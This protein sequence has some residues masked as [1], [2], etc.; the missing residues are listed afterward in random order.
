MNIVTCA[1]MREANRL[2]TE[3]IGIPQIVLMENTALKIL[4]EII[5]ECKD[6]YNKNIIVFAGYGNNGGNALAVA[7]H[8]FT[9][10]AN[11]KVKLVPNDSGEMSPNMVVNLTS[12][13]NMTIDIETLDSSKIQKLPVAIMGSEIVIDGIFGIGLNK[14]IIGIAI[15]VIDAINALNKKVFSLDLP[16]G[17]NC[18]TGR[19]QGRSVKAYKTLTF[20]LPKVGLYMYD[21]PKYTGEIVV[22]DIGIPKKVYEQLNIKLNIITHQDAI[23]PKRYNESSKTSYGKVLVIGGSKGMAGSVTLTSSAALKSGAGLVYLGAPESLNSVL[24][25]KLT[26]VIL[27]SLED[28]SNGVLSI[29]A[30]ETVKENI[31]K[32]NVVAIGPGIS[33][34]TG[35][36]VVV[37]WISE[38]SKVPV[39]L[40]ADALGALSK[41]LSVLS[42]AKAQIIITPHTS[43]MAK[44]IG[45]TIEDVQANRLEVARKFAKKWNVITVLKGAYTIVATPSG[46]DYINVNGNNGMSTAG[47]GDVLTGVI[48]G[49]IA[50]DL[51]PVN[52][53]V[54]GI[55]LHGLA[56]DLCAVNKGYHGMTASDIL[57]QIP[58]TIKKV[59]LSL[60]ED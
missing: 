22:L 6:V 49:L 41:D 30:L 51:A 36:D 5:K 24:A 53:V 31:N 15:N 4:E 20:G 50:Q 17:M 21:S 59:E 32:A 35:V 60:V 44:L 16:S 27:V 23:I 10:G 26:E 39:V 2:A 18:D 28:D 19:I 42:N 8:L 9:K 33:K 52:A 7:R 1:Q 43:E 29:K 56:G 34:G 40:D 58:Y 46:R 38:R 57:A 12:A 25:S 54:T 3:Q 45:G 55:Y 47:S 48:A 37:R 14:D 13:K 11:V